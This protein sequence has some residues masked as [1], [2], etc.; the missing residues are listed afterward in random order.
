MRYH[1]TIGL[2]TIGGWT[3]P[4]CSEFCGGGTARSKSIYLRAGTNAQTRSYF[5]WEHD[6][7]AVGVD[8]LSHAWH[9]T[10]TLYAY[11]PQA[12][13]SMTLQK[14][15]AESVF[16]MVLVTPLFPYASWWPTLMQVSTA[17]PVVLPCQRWVTTDPAGNHSWRHKW[18][19]VVWRVSGHVQYAR[20]CRR[21]IKQRYYY[22][23]IKRQVRSVLRGQAMV[24][25]EAA[26]IMAVMH[27]A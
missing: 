14:V 22:E 21:S 17:V 18:P 12:L 27:D 5:S 13:I 10:R 2:R 3:R 25:H 11:P 16:D 24:R 26:L 7:D 8:S 9:G 23:Q 6:S 4:F 19:L 20:D 1:V 15:I